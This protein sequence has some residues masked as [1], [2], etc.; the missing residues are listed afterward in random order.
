MKL[1]GK[2]TEYTI[3]EIS[4]Y[5][6]PLS[7]IQELINKHSNVEKI[8]QEYKPRKKKIQN[9]DGTTIEKPPDFSLRHQIVLTFDLTFVKI[10]IYSFPTN[11]QEI[12]KMGFESIPKAKTKEKIELAARKLMRT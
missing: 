6:A 2:L 7:T 5:A 11:Y 12:E 9:K 1:I 10:K 8:I 4:L 3:N